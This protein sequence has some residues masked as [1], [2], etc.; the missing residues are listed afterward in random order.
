MKAKKWDW[1]MHWK[2]Q[3][4]FESEELRKR[5]SGHTRTC[6]EASFKGGQGY[7]SD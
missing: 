4:D 5:F 7:V 6:V 3:G 2:Y 1:L